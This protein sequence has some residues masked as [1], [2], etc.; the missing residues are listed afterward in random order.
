M[1]DF[2]LLYKLESLLSFTLF[3]HVLLSQ[4]PQFLLQ[5]QFMCLLLHVL[6]HL[7]PRRLKLVHDPL[8]PLPRLKLL[9]LLPRVLHRQVRLC[10]VFFVVERLLHL[11]FHGLDLLLYFFEVLEESGLVGHPFLETPF[12]EE[13]P[14]SQDV[15]VVVLEGPDFFVEEG[16]KLFF[17]T[18]MLSMNKL[19]VLL[20][21]H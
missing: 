20:A 16:F 1:Y 5:H 19:H 12:G 4:L 9:V 10:L 11:F 18:A 15:L 2:D 6:L 7:L 17:T 13:L 8:G 3:L 14:L 21:R